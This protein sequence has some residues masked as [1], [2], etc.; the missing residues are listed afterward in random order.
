LCDLTQEIL[1]SL[2]E[3]EEEGSGD[4]VGGLTNE[5]ST[6]GGDDVKGVEHLQDGSYQH[7]NDGGR[8]VVGSSSLLLDTNDINDHLQ[9]Q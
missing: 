4:N 9:S 2:E 5:S 7:G 6:R 1:T 3:E 8:V